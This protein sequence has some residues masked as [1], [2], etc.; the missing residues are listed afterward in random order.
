MMRHD[1]NSTDRMLL[2]PPEAAAG[3][4]RECRSARL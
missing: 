3:L 2:R 4:A 1:L